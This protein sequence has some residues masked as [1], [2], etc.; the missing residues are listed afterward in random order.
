MYILM[1][2]HKNIH[3]EKIKRWIKGRRRR[4]KNF[5]TDVT[6]SDSRRQSHTHAVLLITHFLLLFSS[7]SSSSSSSLSTSSPY[8]HTHTQIFYTLSCSRSM[9]AFLLCYA[10]NCVSATTRRSPSAFSYIYT[11][12]YHLFRFLLTIIIYFYVWRVKFIE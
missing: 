5:E 10:Y 3:K 6:V 8:T 1:G 12:C 11:S 2:A 9:M 7:L 4:R